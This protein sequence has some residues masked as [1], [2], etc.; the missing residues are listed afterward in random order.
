MLFDTWAKSLAGKTI[1]PLIDMA[2]ALEAEGVRV[3]IATHMRARGAEMENDFA[4]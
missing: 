3:W 4:R 1:S 2:D